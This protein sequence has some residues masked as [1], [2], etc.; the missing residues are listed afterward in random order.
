M[1]PAATTSKG[2]N[3]QWGWST[4]KVEPHG[5]M[6]V[7]TYVNSATGVPTPNS[8][9]A[10]NTPYI[11]KDILKANFGLFA[12]D[13]WTIS[14]LTMTYGG[15]YDYFSGYAPEENNPAGRFVPDRHSDAVTCIP[16]WSDW[17]IRAGASYDLFGNG[18]TALKTSVGSFWQQALGLTATLNP[19]ASQS[20]RTWTDRDGNGRRS[21]PGQRSPNEPGGS[22]NLNLAIPGG[23]GKI[24][25][26]CRG[27]Q[28]G[29]SVSVQ[30]ELFPA[31]R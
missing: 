5:D 9:T 8:V 17:T 31:F 13:K 25:P 23:A 2:V 15:R 10:R 19:M 3:Q 21:T 11:R 22:T 20:T 28:L 4:V 26:A 30:H 14:R 6:S 24:A 7:L 29:E 16:C 18:K 1:S 27:D 12:Q